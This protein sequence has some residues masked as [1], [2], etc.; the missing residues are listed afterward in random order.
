MFFRSLAPIL[1][2]SACIAKA[3]M[4]PLVNQVFIDYQTYY[5]VPAIGKPLIGLSIGGI[6]ANAEFDLIFSDEWQHHI[7]CHFTDKVSN[8]IDTYSD[9]FQYP[10]AIPLYLVS[11]WLKDIYCYHPSLEAFG[12]WGNHSLRT[13]L[14]GAPQQ[15]VLT[16]ILGGGR[17]E[18]GQPQ[19]HLGR[20]N[21]AI[22]G[23]AFYGAIPMLNLSKMTLNPILKSTFFMLS[24]LP[25]LARIDLNKHYAS[26]AFLGWWLAFCATT[27]IWNADEVSKKPHFWS[28]QIVPLQ[29]GIFLG[30]TAKI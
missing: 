15:A 13:L 3:Q 12:E 7:R 11:M 5:S 2:I 29:E 27:T 14:L 16:A 30:L 20:Y 26:Q 23:D 18:T 19:W 10:T 1:L 9:F 24:L 25:G 21:R 17:P 4:L 22:S 8:N 28:V 6:L